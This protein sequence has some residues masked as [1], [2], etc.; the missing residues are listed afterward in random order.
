LI[1]TAQRTM[2]ERQR[3]RLYRQAE[4][5]VLQ[6]APWVFMWHRADYFVIQP[7][8]KNFKIY[9]LYSIDKRVDVTVKR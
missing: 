7:W 8:V 5:R 9:P 2:D 3:Y 1:E 6:N 4:D